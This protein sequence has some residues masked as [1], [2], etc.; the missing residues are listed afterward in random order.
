[1]PAQSFPN[2]LWICSDQQRHD[3][4]GCYDNPYVHTPNLDRLAAE[5]VRFTHAYCQSPVCTPSRAS[6][7]TGRYPRTTRTR[8]NGQN[9]PTAETLVTR[10]LAEAG[11]VGGLAGKLHIAAA[12]PSAA[13]VVEQ[14]I[15]DGYHEFHWSHT[16]LPSKYTTT[17]A[18]GADSPWAADA[19][20][21]WLREKGRRYMRTPFRHSPYV[22]TSVAAEDHQTTWC[23]E[24]AVQFIERRAEDGQPW[25]FSVNPFDPHHPFDPPEAS[26]ARYLARLDEIPLPNYAPDELDNK[27]I[28]QRIDHRW[29]YNTPGQY[30][31]DE[32]SE[33]DHRLLR[34]AYWAMCDLIDTGVGQILDALERSGQRENTL[35]IFM[36][37][38]GEM[39][40]DHGIYLKGPYFYEPAIRV[41]LIVAGP[42]VQRGKVSKALVELVDLAPTLLDAAGLAPHSGMQGHSLWP[43]L[44]GATP[45]DQHRDDIYCEYYNAMPWHQDPQAHLTMVR[46]ERHK[47]VVAHGLNTG[48]LYDLAVDPM[49]TANQ[50][51]DPGYAAVKSE[52]LLRLCDRMAWTV[53]PLPERIAPW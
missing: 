49:E 35:V 17:G 12:N 31:Y 45:L 42:G 16:P 32:M 11:Y 14:R 36:S 24:M 25:F 10:L 50:W 2:I 48:E 40:G 8:Q 38:H 28:F 6:F 43:L 37:D 26:L 18:S 53:D 23:A 19:Y 30:P 51:N 5:G 21:A 3:T 46:N 4:L 22:Q 52:M 13:P 41:P 44:T 27:P 9:I 29:A 7:L 33:E 20:T 15:P 39:L 47:L 1:M 34:A